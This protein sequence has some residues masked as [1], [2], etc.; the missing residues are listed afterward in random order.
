[1]FYSCCCAY[2]L[3]VLESSNDCYSSFNNCARN[4]VLALVKIYPITQSISVPIITIIMRFID[5]LSPSIIDNKPK[6][7]RYSKITFDNK[8]VI[9]SIAIWGNYVRD[10]K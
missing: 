4:L 7:I 6:S 3:A 5:F 9:F 1:M 2:V 10:K 8:Y